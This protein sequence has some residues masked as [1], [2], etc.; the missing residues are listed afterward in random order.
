M[1]TYN[2]YQGNTKIHHIYSGSDK[3]YYI[4]KGDRLVWRDRHY[5]KGQTVFES[6]VG[7][8]QTFRVQDTGK[9][10]ITCIGGGG[11]ANY[12]CV[13]DD[14]GYIGCGGSGG[15]FS[16]I[17]ELTAG[18]YELTVG[19]CAVGG[20][21]NTIISG[22]IN[23]GGGGDGT[24]APGA[25]GAGAAPTLYVT[26]T[27]VTL[28]TGGNPGGAYASGN[29]GGGRTWNYTGAA[30]IYNGYGRGGGGKVC[31]YASTS[32]ANENSGEPYNPTNGYIK[33]EY[34]EDVA[35]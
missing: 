22:V 5:D 15:G 17:V 33:I 13:Y 35:Q 19:S 21:R 31:E 24:S 34:L 27:D 10:R 25:G 18:N 3:V 1:T 7:G 20:I 32:S 4:Y 2:A 11:R 14:R 29:G 23:V 12:R 28:N 9:Y 30:S 6:S 8:T 26:A 16:G